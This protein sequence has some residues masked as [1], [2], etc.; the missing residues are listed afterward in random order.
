MARETEM[1]IFTRTFDFLTWLLPLT[2]TFPRAHRFTVTSR[3]L[4]AAFDL[5]ERLEEAQYRS[6]KERSERLQRAD[7][8]LSRVR[9]YLRL[10]AKWEWVTEGQYHH[11]AQMVAEIGRLLGGWK[12][13][14]AVM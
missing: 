4:D 1:P 12:K 11:A 10:A 13:V 5:R 7:E 14:G 9:L 6:G 2:N 3:L 8:A